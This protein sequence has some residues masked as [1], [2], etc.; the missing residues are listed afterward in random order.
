VRLNLARARALAEALERFE[1]ENANKRSECC[2][3]DGGETLRSAEEKKKD[4]SGVPDPSIAETRGCEHPE[5]NP[6][7]R[8]PTVQPAHHAVIAALDETP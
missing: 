1:Y 2:G 5:A 6:P 4:G 7:R 3:T 8:T